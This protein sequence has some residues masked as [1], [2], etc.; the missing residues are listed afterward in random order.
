MGFN[1]LVA[2]KDSELT[3]EMN[4]CIAWLR[5]EP[6]FGVDGR[7][8]P[9]L[10]S[11]VCPFRGPD[12]PAGVDAMLFL[13]V[14]T[15]D[16]PKIVGFR[17][18][19]IA[20]PFLERS[21]AGVRVNLT[22][23]IDECRGSGFLSLFNILTAA[24]LY[25]QCPMIDFLLV[26]INKVN[27]KGNYNIYMKK[28]FLTARDGVLVYEKAVCIDDLNDD[29]LFDDA[30]GVDEDGN[31]VPPP[32]ERMNKARSILATDSAWKAYDELHWPSGYPTD[33]VNLLVLMQDPDKAEE[34]EFCE[35]WKKKAAEAEDKKEKEEIA[36]PPKKAQV[37]K[38]APTDAR[39][40]ATKRALSQ[41]REEWGFWD[42]EEKEEEI[43]NEMKRIIGVEQCLVSA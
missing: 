16:K 2:R 21:R 18:L 8:K 36:P 19:T 40:K 11:D 31:V 1:V 42:K 17:T 12:C 10:V 25:E 37:A 34:N 6:V 20:G 14:E 15:K 29:D 24:P 7:N 26:E 41:S 38:A 23:M 5:E 27:T 30:V 35:E 33:T 39:R 28:G 9:K 3:P 4:G 22:V 13:T 43:A 32:D